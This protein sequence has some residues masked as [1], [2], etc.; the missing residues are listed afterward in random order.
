LILSYL[1]LSS[2][3]RVRAASLSAVNSFTIGSASATTLSMFASVPVARRVASAPAVSDL[4]L[5]ALISPM[6]SFCSSLMALFSEI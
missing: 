6:R 5:D 4:S 1:A 3:K 2:S